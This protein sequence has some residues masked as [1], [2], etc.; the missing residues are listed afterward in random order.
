MVRKY[1][2]GGM[3][4]YLRWE[5]FSGREGMVISEMN[6]S[7]ERIGRY[8]TAGNF[9]IDG[10]GRSGTRRGSGKGKH[11]GNAISSRPVTVLPSLPSRQFT[12]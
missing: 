4:R 2:L 3:G 5:M 8:F 11:S 10:A 12:T 6:F 7:I 9:L 1:F